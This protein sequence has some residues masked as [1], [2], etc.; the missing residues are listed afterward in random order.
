MTN[1]L[2]MFSVKPINKSALILTLPKLT[3]KITAFLS[4]RGQIVSPQ[5]GEFWKTLNLMTYT[6][7]KVKNAWADE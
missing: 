6:K 3:C 7:T 5:P 1:L 2:S 4:T